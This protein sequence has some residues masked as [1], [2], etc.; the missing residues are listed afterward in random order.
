MSARWRGWMIHDATGKF[1]SLCPLPERSSPAAVMTKSPLKASSNDVQKY[2]S[3]RRTG[4]SRQPKELV[5]LKKMRHNR[6]EAASYPTLA[7]N[8]RGPKRL[9]NRLFRRLRQRFARL[10]GV[11][12][13]RLMAA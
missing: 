4:S 13:G 6:R 7:G 12:R 11:I 3:D 8:A 1:S 10:V 9:K 5:S 2:T